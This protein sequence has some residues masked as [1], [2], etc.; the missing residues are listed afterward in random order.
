MKSLMLATALILASS[1]AYSE[2]PFRVVSILE[3]RG[4]VVDGDGVLIRGAEVRLQG[5]AAPGRQS[6]PC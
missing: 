3:G 1:K 5:I 6:V 4:N 2:P